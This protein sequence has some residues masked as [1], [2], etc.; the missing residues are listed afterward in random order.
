MSTFQAL[1]LLLGAA[2][3]A[4]YVLVHIQ[5]VTRSLAAMIVTGVEDGLPVSIEYRWHLFWANY[6]PSEPTTSPPSFLNSNLGR[7]GSNLGRP[8]WKAW[9]D[10]FLSGFLNTPAPAIAVTKGHHATYSGHRDRLDRAGLVA[11]IHAALDAKAVTPDDAANLI[12]LIEGTLA[13]RHN[14]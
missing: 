8:G 5:G 10:A 11:K 1:A 14:I 13:S 9:F 2:I 6:L 7:P 4:V 12:A 3:S